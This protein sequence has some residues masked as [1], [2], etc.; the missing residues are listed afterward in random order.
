MKG[1]EGLPMPLQ[2]PVLTCNPLVRVW[3]EQKLMK[4]AVSLV[5]L[6]ICEEGIELKILTLLM[7]PGHLS[8]WR[9][10]HRRFQSGRRWTSG[11]RYPLLH[12]W[13]LH[14]YCCCCQWPPWSLLL[15]RLLRW[16]KFWRFLLRCWLWQHCCYC[17]WP[18][19][20][21]HQ[22]LHLHPQSFA[23]IE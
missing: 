8:E 17:C 11:M 3:P 15:P 16:W 4:F 2:E 5:R 23:A 9:F 12:Y 6:I 22:S 19:S 13:L 1:E 10:H 7:Q 14:C 18:C 20:V 21:L